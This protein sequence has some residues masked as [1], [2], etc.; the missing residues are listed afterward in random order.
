MILEFRTCAT[1]V[2]LMCLLTAGHIGVWVRACE[3]SEDEGEVSHLLI[4]NIIITIIIIIISIIITITWSTVGTMSQKSSTS[5]HCVVR[6]WSSDTAIME[7]DG[8][9]AHTGKELGICLI[10][11][12]PI[13]PKSFRS[14]VQCWWKH[15]NTLTGV[16]LSVMRLKLPRLTPS[17]SALPL[18]RVLPHNVM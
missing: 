1:A 4:I 15:A 11:P 17:A 8:V 12:F 14:F 6:A 5:Q 16:E 13:V 9:W 2:L 7:L 18:P 10:I 3:E